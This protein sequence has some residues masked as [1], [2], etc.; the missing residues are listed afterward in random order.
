MA[1]IKYDASIKSIFVFY[2]TFRYIIK[3]SIQIMI[4]IYSISNILYFTLKIKN[5]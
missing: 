5:I 2:Q 1:P 4:L 3:K